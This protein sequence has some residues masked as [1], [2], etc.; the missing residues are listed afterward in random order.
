MQRLKNYAIPFLIIALLVLPSTTS[1][2]NQVPSPNF[3]PQST[4]RPVESPGRVI[5][6]TK[7][8]KKQKAMPNR[9][10]I[11][12][13]DD[14]V[15]D[16][17]PVEVRREGVSAIAS[18]HAHP[19]GGAVDYIYETALKGYAIQLPT[20][21][22]A[23]AISKLPRVRW[24]EEDGFVELAQAPPS[25]Q[26]S[27]PWG[28]DSL[29]TGIPVPSPNPTT[30]RNNGFYNYGANGTGVLVYVL[31]TGINTAHQEFMTPFFSRAIQAANCYQFV[32]CVSGQTTPFANFQACGTGMPNPINNDCH[33]HGTF[34]AG[35]LGGN[36]FGAAKNVTIRSVKVISNSNPAGL[37]SAVIA[38]MNWVTGQ[39]QANPSLPAVANV[40][41]GVNVEGLAVET[42]VTNS[43]NAGVS[44]VAAAG[45]E[46]QNAE[47]WSPQNVRDVLVVGAVDWTGSRW[48]LSNW[49]PGVDLFAP[50]VSIVSALTG[51]NLCLWHGNNNETCIL[52]GTSFAAPHVTG[53][54]AMYLQGR[55]GATGCNLFPIQGVSPP[56]G[57]L[58]TCPDR[59]ARFIIANARMNVL[60]SN[61]NGTLPSPNRFISTASIPGPANPIDNNAFFIWTQYRDFLGR[62]PEPTGLTAWVNIL[63]NC[64]PSGKD[65]NGNWCDRIEVSSGFFRS[66][67]FQVR[68]YFIYRFY[69]TVGRIPVYPEFQVDFAK[70]SGFL[71]EQQ[72]EANKVAFVNEFM[73]RAEFQNRYGSTFNNPTAYVDALLQTVGLP[74]HPSRGFWINGLTNGSQSRAQ[75]L[76][77]L[78]ESTEMYLKYYNEAF[79]IMSYFGYLRRTADGAYVDWI[80]V[81]NQT[82]DYRVLINGFMNSSEYRRRFGP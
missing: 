25:P 50:G 48:V 67:E 3:S 12:L 43:M 18:S 45:N 51:N 13:D 62:E 1:S 32:N 31:D 15:S 11:V 76:R 56:S 59:V 23:I 64:P 49:G 52:S 10:I 9:Y 16:N 7:F 35:V 78:V 29:D 70:V 27:P 4:S 72:L 36:N 8:V 38:G 80:N 19:H 33:G 74:N 46:N 63:N 28:L 47:V 57:N 73:A 55:P 30:G 61:I 54:I 58:S 24:V 5:P 6:S 14:I 37:E 66:A 82:G 60:N 53:A 39:H 75:V 71:T 21:A 17:V 26:P 34:V 2:Q 69:S 81:M 22:A 65:A 40:S 79:V 44:Y 41:L 42:A 68:G 77:G 20:E